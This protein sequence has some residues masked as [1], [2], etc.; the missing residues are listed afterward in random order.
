[1]KPAE[2]ILQLD[3]GGGLWRLVLELGR[4]GEARAV[5]RQSVLYW[6]GL[7]NVSYGLKFSF[8]RPP[9]NL[10]S[11]SCAGIKL[12]PTQMD[13][14]DDHSRLIKLAFDVGGGKRARCC[15]RCPQEVIMTPQI[16]ERLI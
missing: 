7:K 4:V 6:S 9:K 13:P 14:A 11:S 8:E 2:A 5:Q 10:I 1:M 16:S 15:L 3:L 12:S